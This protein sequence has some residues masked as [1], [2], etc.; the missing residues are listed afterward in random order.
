M[1]DSSLQ[2]HSNVQS[3]ICLILPLLPFELLG[4]IFAGRIREFYSLNHLRARA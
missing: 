2:L 1:R 3:E 4:C